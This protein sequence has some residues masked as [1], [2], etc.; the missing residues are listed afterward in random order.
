MS[1]AG[2]PTKYDALALK[3][4][5]SYVRK[6]QKDGCIPFVEE[7]ALEIGVND[8]TLV[9]W[10]GKH[11]EFSATVKR[12]KT[13]QKLHLKKGALERK[14]HPSIAMFLL[15][16]N[17]DVSE[18][19]ADFSLSKLYDESEPERDKSLAPFQRIWKMQLPRQNMPERTKKNLGMLLKQSRQ[20]PEMLYWCELWYDVPNRGVGTT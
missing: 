14:L 3:T 11:G 9:E 6:C 1:L 16:A 10:V 17:H 19:A 5:Q 12:L 18:K 8:D 7:L 20:I 13:L 2:R 15:K 4:A